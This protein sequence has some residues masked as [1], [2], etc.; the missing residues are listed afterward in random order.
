MGLKFSDVP[1]GLA[2]ITKVDLGYLSGM[3]CWDDQHPM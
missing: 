3:G 2:A 1:N